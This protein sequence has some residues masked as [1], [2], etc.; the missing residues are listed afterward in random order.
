VANG[1]TEDRELVKTV[2][3]LEVEMKHVKD[4]LELMGSRFEERFERLEMLMRQTYIPRAE[5][6]QAFETIRVELKAIDARVDA[7]VEELKDVKQTSAETA[8]LAKGKA[9]EWVTVVFGVLMTAIGI[10]VGLVV[11]KGP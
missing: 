2:A 10:L 1:E 4:M 8:K 7:V 5:V 11:K 9:P 3:G 6:N